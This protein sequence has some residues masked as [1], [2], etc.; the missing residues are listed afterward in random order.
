MMQA[1]NVYTAEDS[2]TAEATAASRTAMRILADVLQRKHQKR[3]KKT[4]R[5]GIIVIIA[6]IIVIM[7]TKKAIIPKKGGGN[8]GRRR[9]KER[10]TSSSIT[11]IDS[12]SRTSKDDNIVFLVLLIS[13]FPCALQMMSD[14]QPPPPYPQQRLTISGHIK[15][16]EARLQSISGSWIFS[17]ISNISFVNNNCWNTI[18]RHQEHLQQHGRF[19]S[20]SSNGISISEAS[21]WRPAGEAAHHPQGHRQHHAEWPAASASNQPSHEEHLWCLRSRHR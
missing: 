14:D 19:S 7:S 8:R 3:R 9:R 11:I 13:S 17:S 20:S 16:L 18:Q 15:D 1:F 4:K 21:H 2:D 12:N 10:R 5:K 6:T